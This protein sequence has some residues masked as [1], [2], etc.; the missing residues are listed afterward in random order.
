MPIVITND[1][2][3]ITN[4]NGDLYEVII[5]SRS[6]GWTDT[7]GEEVAESDRG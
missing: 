7:A 5:R 2:I 4:D 3:F 6:G 1:N